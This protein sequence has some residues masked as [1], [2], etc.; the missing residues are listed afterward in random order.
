MYGEVGWPLVASFLLEHTITPE[1]WTMIRVI[2]LDETRGKIFLS[3][4]SLVDIDIG[5]KLDMPI[6]RGD[7]G[8][9]TEHVEKIDV[10]LTAPRA[11]ETVQYETTELDSCLLHIQGKNPS[12][13]QRIRFQL[14]KWVLP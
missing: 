5:H 8:V 11:W 4:G 7:L 9:I 6:N 12:L 10:S 14:G 2:V 1:A 3:S 13:L